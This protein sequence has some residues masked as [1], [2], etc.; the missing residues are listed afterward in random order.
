MGK[1]LE[2]E[3]EGYKRCSKCRADKPTEEFWKDSS[4]HDGLNHHC[5]TCSSAKF[6]KWKDEHPEHVKSHRLKARY[7]IDRTEYFKIAEEQ[8]NLCKI[9]NRK[10][11]LFVDHCHDTGKI[12]GLLCQKCNSALG[13]LDDDVSHVRSMLEYMENS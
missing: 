2:S 3:I 9:C 4:R 6:K 11:K 13:F 12:R 1:V 10:R 7:G 8:N 5:N